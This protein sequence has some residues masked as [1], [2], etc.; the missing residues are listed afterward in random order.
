MH[1]L[2]HGLAEER[3]SSAHFQRDPTVANA[4]G[5]EVPGKPG[6][7]HHRGLASHRRPATSGEYM[8]HKNTSCINILIPPVNMI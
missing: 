6:G 3:R 1:G 5:T 2:V 8:F 4:R 7:D